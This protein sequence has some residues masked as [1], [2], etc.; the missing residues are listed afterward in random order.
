VYHI[1]ISIH[2]QLSQVKYA[3]QLKLSQCTVLLKHLRA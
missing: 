2:L 3:D 1:L